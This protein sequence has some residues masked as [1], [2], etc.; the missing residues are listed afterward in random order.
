MHQF[1]NNPS[2][3]LLLT[4]NNSLDDVDEYIEKSKTVQSKS[5]ASGLIGI[6]DG[7]AIYG[8]FTNSFKK[9]LL[10]IDVKYCM[11]NQ[12]SESIIENTLIE[13]YS[14]YILFISNPFFEPFTFVNNINPL[15]ENTCEQSCQTSSINQFKTVTQ[16]KFT[17]KLDSILMQLNNYE[18]Q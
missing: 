12:I 15:T 4:M 18:I 16:K 6:L 10:Y 11:M 5:L 9:I 7:Y 2:I 3:E 1:G 17:D 14:A 8:Y 13:L